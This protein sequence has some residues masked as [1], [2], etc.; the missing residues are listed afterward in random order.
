MSSSIAAIQNNVGGGGFE[1][2]ILDVSERS[3]MFHRLC[4]L[5]EQLGVVTGLGNLSLTTCPKLVPRISL[6]EIMGHLRVCV[7]DHGTF[8]F[9]GTQVFMV[10]F[11]KARYW[12]QLESIRS[13]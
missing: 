8:C 9:Y 13:S 11:I 2:R 7:I 1:E 6:N 3:P 4:W 12:V 5:V 10:V